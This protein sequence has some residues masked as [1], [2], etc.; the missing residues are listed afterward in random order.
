MKIFP[1]LFLIVILFFESCGPKKPRIVTPPVIVPPPTHLEKLAPSQYPVFT[2]DLF[3]DGLEQGIAQSLSYYKVIPK[4]RMFQFGNDRYDTRQMIESLTTF[5]A[6]IAQAD[7]E[8]DLNKFIK[9]RFEVYR[10][11]GDDGAGHVLYTGYYESSLR[12]SLEKSDDYPYPVFATPADLVTI[13]LRLFSDEDAF[14]TTL[15]GRYTDDKTIV[16]YYE[17]KDISNG[18]V[19]KDKA[20][21]IAYVSDKVDL[22]FLEV[23]G[24]GII[25]LD[26]GDILRVHYHNKN[27]K[28]YRSIGTHLIKTGKINQKSMSMQKIRE[29][30]HAH[31][32]QVD[33]VLNY[34]PSYVFFK[35][36]KGGPYGC[37]GVEVTAE[38]S[39]ATDKRLFPACSLAFIETSKPLIDGDG[40]IVEWAPSRR[41]ALNQD[42]GGAIRGPGR[43]DLFKGSGAYAETAAGHMKHKGSLYFF[44]LKNRPVPPQNPVPA[45][46]MK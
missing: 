23:Q 28:P 35:T 39:I 11:A 15:V 44:V 21:I 38:R 46:Q 41:F 36:E 1:L 27:G 34:N 5:Q 40:D 32:D 7:P 4:D 17:R 43:V 22:F 16:P 33:Q 37:Y 24:S 19:L 2:D 20:E 9:D 6:F 18:D 45:P 10:S 3:F 12:G 31:P 14:K 26:N 42:T 25:Y 29:Y 30:L 13:N 8:K